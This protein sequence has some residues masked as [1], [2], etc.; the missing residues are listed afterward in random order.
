MLPMKS[1]VVTGFMTALGLLL[2]IG[3]PAVSSSL[4]VPNS[5]VNQSGA[6]SGLAGGKWASLPDPP[7]PPRSSGVVLWTGKGLLL[8]GGYTDSQV[9]SGRYPSSFGRSPAGAIYSVSSKSWA[10]VSAG[11][12]SPRSDV[13]AVWTGKWAVLWGGDRRTSGYGPLHLFK[14]GAAYSPALREWRKLP[15]APISARF[16]ATA[17]WTGSRVVII[18]GAGSTSAVFGSG[19]SFDPTTW[20]WSTLPSIPPARAGALVGANFVWTGHELIGFLVYQI[21]KRLSADETEIRGLQRVV[22]LAADA[23]T[24]RYLQSP[25]RGIYTLGAT[26]LWTGSSALLIGGTYCL[27]GEP[28]PAPGNSEAVDIF[29]P[30]RDTWTNWPANPI[31]ADDSS[32]VAVWTGQ[33]LLVINTS[34]SGGEGSN[35][36]TPG[37]GVAF[38]PSSRSWSKVPTA[39]C[40][41]PEFGA[42]T[43][44]SVIVF[45]I[46]GT[47]RHWANCTSV[48]IP[49]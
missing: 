25:P 28:C 30:T 17:L 40:T 46:S 10:T 6:A 9:T 47:P 34:V 36:V 38:D 20:K 42:W 24:W 1:A 37:E 12:L 5:A 48:L 19:V 16:A 3:L 33:A 11:P 18:G 7:I 26:A 22:E 45:G 23:K 39:P 43:D 27:P 32:G 15:P 21:V 14:D 44:L 31:V 2:A 35:V 13:A 41:S 4:G 29:D 8:W 49:N